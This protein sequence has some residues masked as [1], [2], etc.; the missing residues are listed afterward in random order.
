M[1]SDCTR[2][3]NLKVVSIIIVI[4]IIKINLVV[5]GAK[6]AEFV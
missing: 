2:H 3:E 1:G 6:V 5:V 4:I